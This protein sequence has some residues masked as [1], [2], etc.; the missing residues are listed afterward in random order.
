MTVLDQT[1]LSRPVPR[2]STAQ[3]LPY[4]DDTQT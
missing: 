2:E 4:P 1:A 3:P